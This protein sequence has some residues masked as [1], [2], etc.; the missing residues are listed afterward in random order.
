LLL[1]RVAQVALMFITVQRALIA[2]LIHILAAVAAKHIFMHPVAR[3]NIKPERAIQQHFMKHPAV[4]AV[5]AQ[6]AQTA[7]QAH[8]AAQVG[9]VLLIL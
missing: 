4:V 8:K 6:M 5:R 7:T 2:H 1:V 9:Q 3:Q